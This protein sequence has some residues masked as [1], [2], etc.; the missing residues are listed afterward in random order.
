MTKPSQVA[1][2]SGRIN[3]D[4]IVRSLY[5]RDRFRKARE[6]DRLVLIELESGTARDAKMHGHPQV[7]AS[8]LGPCSPVVDIPRK[9]LLSGIEIDCRDALTEIQKRDRDMHGCGGFARSALLITNHDDVRRLSSARV[10]L[11]QHDATTSAGAFLGRVQCEAK[12]WN[13]SAGLTIN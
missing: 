7:E 4:E 9:A 3:N 10:R 12:R 1:V 2:G 5:G 8:L 6:L 11:K 13:E